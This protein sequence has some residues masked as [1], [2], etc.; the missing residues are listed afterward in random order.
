MKTLTSLVLVSL[1][2]FAACVATAPT[3]KYYHKATGKRLAV[4]PD[5][6]DLS[7][8]S[9]GGSASASGP[10]PWKASDMRNALEGRGIN[11]RRANGTATYR[12]SC[13]AA[14]CNGCACLRSDGTCKLVTQEVE[15]FLRRLDH[16][17]AVSR[18]SRILCG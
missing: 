16:F 1:V 4:R 14:T 11:L 5:R 9:G 17:E 13:R 15:A 18:K 10:H 2:L 12:P 3:V 6:I 8:L 7:S